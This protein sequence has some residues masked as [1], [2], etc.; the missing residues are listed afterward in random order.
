[1]IYY[2]GGMLKGIW[3]PARL[4]QSYA[5]LIGLALYTGFILTR[6]HLPK[7]YRFLP[8]DRGREFTLTKEAA[9]GKPTGSGYFAIS[10]I[11]NLRVSTVKQ[12]IRTEAGLTVISI[13]CIKTEKTAD[14]FV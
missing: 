12:E 3:G 2:L 4:L 1:M 6:I 10:H 7:L 14:S 9:K 13:Y 5:V 8:C 11:I